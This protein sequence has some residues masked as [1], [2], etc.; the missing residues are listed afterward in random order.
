[1]EFSE[2]RQP[3]VVIVGAGFGGLRAAKRL[4]GGPVD[5]ILVD[6]HNYHTFMPLLYQVARAALEPEEIAYPVRRVFRGERNINFRLAR[7]E[8]VDLLRQRLLTSQGPITYDYLI[9]AAGS[10][11]NFFGQA[12]IQQHAYGLHDLKDA[13]ALRNHLLTVFEQVTQETDPARRAALLT[14][15]IVG[16]GPT[17]VELAGAYSELIQTVLAQE[18]PQLDFSQVR[19]L[20]LEGGPALL[21]ALPPDLR[22]AALASLQAKGVEVRLRTAVASATADEVRLKDGTVIPTATLVW[23]AGVRAADL[24]ATLGQATARGGRVR[25]R[26]TLQLPTTP[27]VFV[28]GDIADLEEDGKAL[29]QVAQVA[30]QQ[31][32]HAAANILH[33]LHGEP[34]VPFRYHDLGTMATIGRHAA[35]G[36]IGPW[37]LKGFI[38]W[39]MWLFIHIVQLIGVRNRLFVLINWLQDYLFY[40]RSARLITTEDMQRLGEPNIREDSGEPIRAANEMAVQTGD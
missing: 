10:A 13:V 22:E 40:A 5:V 2:K 39:L 8:A 1:M 7:V 35:V 21:A 17:G 16:G 14:F 30:M 27:N 15:V 18:Y 12:D 38:G 34:L 31:G 37:R 11:T 19:I 20:L 29:P 28:I 26:E 4:A 33:H 25:V 6:Q 23:A 36:Q 3:L 9:L 24:A 32:T